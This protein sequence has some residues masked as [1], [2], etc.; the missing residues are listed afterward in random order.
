MEIT[1]GVV[2]VIGGLIGAVLGAWCAV[3]FP[4]SANRRQA[5]LQLL[6]RYTSPEFFVARSEAWRIRRAWEN[7][8]RSCVWFFISDPNHPYDPDAVAKCSN[9][10]TPHQNLSW[11]LHFFASAQLY[12]EAGLVDRPLLKSMFEPH[13]DWYKQFF[14]SSATN[15][16]SR[17]RPASLS[18]LGLLVCP[19]SR[20]F[21]VGEKPNVQT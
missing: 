9:G 7:G 3:W 4:R 12:Y 18:Q 16:R 14:A 8:D 1:I 13:Y 5:T 10:L 11:L 17:C 15:I 19:S 6:E 20:R 21:L 2:G